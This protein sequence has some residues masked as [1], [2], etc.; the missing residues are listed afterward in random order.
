MSELLLLSICYL[1]RKM[2]LGA[3]EEDG[4]SGPS[5]R[6]EKKKLVQLQICIQSVYVMCTD[7]VSDCIIVCV[8]YCVSTIVKRIKFNH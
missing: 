6:I 4:G 2:M 3:K 5:A 1:T 7:S 8:V